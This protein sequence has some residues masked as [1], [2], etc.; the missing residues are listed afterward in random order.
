[1]G[2]D[3]ATFLAVTSTTNSGNIV[4]GIFS[5]GGEDERTYS[6]S[7]LGSKAA[8]RQWGLDAHS[9]IEVDAS[10]T[11]EDFFLNNGWIL[12]GGICNDTG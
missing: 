7:G 9:R 10:P 3:V 8:G 4:E 1:M 11:R 12:P 5:L 2:S 6:V